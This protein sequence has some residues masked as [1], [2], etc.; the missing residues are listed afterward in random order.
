MGYSAFLKPR[1]ETI[2][3]EG[4]EGIIDLANLRKRSL[5]PSNQHKLCENTQRACENHSPV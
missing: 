5:S 3:E 4:I 2:S 1:Q